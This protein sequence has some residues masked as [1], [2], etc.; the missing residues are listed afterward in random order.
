[1]RGPWGPYQAQVRARSMRAACRAPSVKPNGISLGTSTTPI[2][3]RSD[4][5]IGWRMKAGVGCW[6][7]ASTIG[8]AADFSTTVLLPVDGRPCPL[9]RRLPNDYREGP[10]GGEPP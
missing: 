3:R 9:A 1:M 4:S 5:N 8:I 7:H 6:I 2:Q 10:N